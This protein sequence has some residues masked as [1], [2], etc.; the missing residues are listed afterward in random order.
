M[1]RL[2]IDSFQRRPDSGLWALSSGQ[3][4]HYSSHESANVRRT[5]VLLVGMPTDPTDY[6]LASRIVQVEVDPD[7]PIRR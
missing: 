1:I 2:I 5:E 6:H 4:T 3:S 7:A